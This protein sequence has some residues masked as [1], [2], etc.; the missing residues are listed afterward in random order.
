MRIACICLSP[1][2]LICGGCSLW[3]SATYAREVS[4]D[5]ER[6]FDRHLN[7]ELIR[8]EEDGTVVIRA[9]ETNEIFSANNGEP[10]LAK[11]RDIGGHNV[12]LFGENGLSVLSS[13]H[14]EQ[15]AIL[16]HMWSR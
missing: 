13:S 6:P 9:N 16:L 4:L 12:R 2:L 7:V 1:L 3:S 14:S 11:Y 5:L 15:S 10:F 8:V